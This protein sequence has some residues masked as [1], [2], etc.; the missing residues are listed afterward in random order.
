MR[1]DVRRRGAGGLCS[2]RCRARGVFDVELQTDDEAAPFYAASGYVF[3][4]RVRVLSR[5]YTL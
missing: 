4:P 5:S 1:E 2:E 3:E